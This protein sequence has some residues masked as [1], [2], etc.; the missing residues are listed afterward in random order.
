MQITIV[1]AGIM[2]RLWAAYL[3]SG[4]RDVCLFDTSPEVVADLIQHGITVEE[5]GGATRTVTVRAVSAVD[6]LGPQDLIFFL[7][8]SEQTE[9]AARAVRGLAGPD[10]ALVTLQNGWGHGGTL[11]EIF[12]PAQIVIGTTYQGGSLTHDG[13]VFHAHEGGTIVGPYA[14][15]GDLRFAQLAS[16]TL[17]AAGIRATASREARKAIWDKLTFAAAV[18]PVAALTGL[19]N[20]RDLADPAVLPVI[21]E[22][23]TEVA[24]EANA[25]GYAMSAD[26]EV[27]RIVTRLQATGYAKASML[28]DVEAHRKTEVD[29]ITGEIVRMAR[30]RG[31]E[32]PVCAAVTAL[33]HGRELSWR[34][35]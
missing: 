8:K 12:P 18:L 22:I 34:S 35:G 10:T 9:P 6:G 16:S 23:V 4:E 20:G 32:A 24:A 13:K 17:N 28:Q 26:E 11:S 14:D 27:T 29:F 33:V 30:S 1:G 3:T 19:D 31:G 2:G 7:V 5:P 25:R 21:N 15:G